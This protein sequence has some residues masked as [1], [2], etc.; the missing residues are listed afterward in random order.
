MT[1]LFSK[2]KT[3][4][5]I[6][7]PSFQYNET[8]QKPFYNFSKKVSLISLSKLMD[9]NVKIIIEQL[10]NFGKSSFLPVLWQQNIFKSAKII[11]Y[12]YLTKS[13]LYLSIFLSREFKSRLT[14]EYEKESIGVWYMKTE[15]KYLLAKQMTY[16]ILILEWI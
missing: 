6:A 15:L 2:L 8:S 1:L 14:C 9:A 16:P 7:T 10:F 13:L 11:H 3:I 5:W 12:L 4:L